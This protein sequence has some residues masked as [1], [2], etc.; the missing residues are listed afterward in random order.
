MVAAADPTQLAAAAAVCAK[1]F[2]AAPGYAALC[3]AAIRAVAVRALAVR[4]SL[5]ASHAVAILQCLI[6]SSTVQATVCSTM[7]ARVSEE[8]SAAPLLEDDVIALCDAMRSCE[9]AVDFPPTE[10]DAVVSAARGALEQWVAHLARND[11]FETVKR[12]GALLVA[13]DAVLGAQGFADPTLTEAVAVACLHRARH[14]RLDVE[15]LQTI[16]RVVGR[17][18]TM[19]DRM[20]SL[21]ASGDETNTAAIT[22]TLLA[23]LRSHAAR[24]GIPSADAQNVATLLWELHRCSPLQFAH[25]SETMQL[26]S[27]F[28]SRLAIVGKNLTVDNIARICVVYRDV[29]R[30]SAATDVLFSQLLATD[31]NTWSA[32]VV[33][34]VST[35][36]ATLC[37]GDRRLM[38]ALET[39]A[40]VVLSAMN[41]ATLAQTLQVFAR[42]KSAVLGDAAAAALQQHADAYDAGDSQNIVFHRLDGGNATTLLWSLVMLRVDK[43]NPLFPRLLRIV[44]DHRRTALLT[45]P[46]IL[47]QLHVAFETLGRDLHPDLYDI[48]SSRRSITAQL[49]A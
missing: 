9:T 35:A 41:A 1:L 37:P 30:S 22:S 42:N 11:G 25:A 6:V 26:L 7:L 3:K 49:G 2:T 4:E 14:A 28:E 34:D 40:A 29:R 31:P 10:L 23:D 45:R 46:T 43:A 38:A 5:A 48:V 33:R 15:D 36:A 20:V 13:V 32:S 39:R 8:R 18:Q 47:Q 27:A 21:Q 17:Q 12:F 19:R 16:L 24:V 44:F